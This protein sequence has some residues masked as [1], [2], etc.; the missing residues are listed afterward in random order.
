VVH[1]VGARLLVVQ[2]RGEGAGAVE[3]VHESLIKSWP[4]LQHWLDE[5]Q[6]DVAYLGQI[7]ASAK[8]WDAKGRPEGL[9]WR[10]EAMEELRLW[11]ARYQGELPD[12]ERAFVD[13]VIEL[14]TRATRR[15]RRLIGAAFAVLL[16]LVAGA[17]VALV[18]INAANQRAQE[19]A[20]KAIAARDAV[21]QEQA[22]KEEALAREREAL[23]KQLVA[24][25]EAAAKA[26]L[27]ADEA[28]RAK[29][30]TQVAVK[31]QASSAQATKQKQQAELAAKK[32]AQEAELAQAEAAKKA[33]AAK[34]A[35]ERKKKITSGPLR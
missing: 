22:K 6:E 30:A 14:G 3:L 10:A 2:T 11:H 7:R 26:K 21:L 8:Q 16:V 15:K 9:L 33:A 20:T 29:Q 34:A 18:K 25:K 13:A 28:V 32:S 35:E 1:L 23:E 31:A 17:G 27:A 24:E 19:E 4:T 5:N 12:R